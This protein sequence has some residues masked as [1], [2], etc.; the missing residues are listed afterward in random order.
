M[1]TEEFEDTLRQFLRR[2]PFQPFIVERNDGTVIEVNSRSLAFAGGA[3]TFVTPNFD[4]VEF[5]C[6]EVRAI[7]EPAPRT[8]P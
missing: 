1:T 7:R 3:A 4:F 6:E 8:A 5:A 2:E